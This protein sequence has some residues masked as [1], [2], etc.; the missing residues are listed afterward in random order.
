M[1]PRHTTRPFSEQAKP[2][3]LKKLT[4]VL[5]PQSLNTNKRVVPESGGYLPDA[6]AEAAQQAGVHRGLRGLK[7]A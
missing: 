5:V 1:F 2:H 4:L 7:E 6:E 3:V